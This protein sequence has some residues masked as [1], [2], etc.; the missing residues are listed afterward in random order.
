MTNFKLE[1]SKMFIKNVGISEPWN[2]YT[3]RYYP[4]TKRD[5]PLRPQYG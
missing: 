5:K 1:L 4:V 2:T 3:E